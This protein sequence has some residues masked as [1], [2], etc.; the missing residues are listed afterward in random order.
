MRSDLAHTGPPAMASTA[1][2]PM[3]RIIV[4]FPDMFEPLT[5]SRRSVSSRR[6]SFVILR[7]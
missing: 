3:L 6:M 1:A 4:L 7:S 5:T 2:M